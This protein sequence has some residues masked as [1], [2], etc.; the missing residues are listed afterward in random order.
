VGALAIR[1]KIG[2]ASGADVRPLAELRRRLGSDR[3]G[4]A[5]LSAMD[6]E[7]VGNLMQMLDQEEKKKTAGD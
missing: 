3:F 7:S 4:A 6:E 1:L 5:L 2:I